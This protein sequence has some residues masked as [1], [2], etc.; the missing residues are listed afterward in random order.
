VTA[1]AC[2][3]VLKLLCAP[4]L[5][6]LH[7]CPCEFYLQAKASGQIAV[8]VL[9]GTLGNDSQSSRPRLLLPAGLEVVLEKCRPESVLTVL[10]PAGKSSMQSSFKL[11][12][13][14]TIDCR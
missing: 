1:S 6:N 8:E 5:L 12:F 2:D 11:S 4:F 3:D 7:S 13:V 9:D 10:I 14:E